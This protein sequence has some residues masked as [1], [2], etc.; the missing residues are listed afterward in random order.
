MASD[1]HD[2]A[3]ELFE[4]LASQRNDPSIRIELS[5]AY[6]DS[7]P[8]CGGLAAIVCKGSRAKKSLDELDILVD[9]HPESWLTFYARGTNHLH[10]PR[11]LRHSDAAASDFERCVELQSQSG[12]VEP[13]HLR[14]WISLG[15]A[16]AKAGRYEAA[17]DA[18]TRGQEV[19]P[20]SPE[21]EQHLAIQ[22]DGALLDFVQ[23]QRSLEQEI[24]TDLT[25]FEG[26]L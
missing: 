10:W 16:Y 24:D 14:T 3:I 9:E 25:F 8:S 5:L 2:R 19:F 15:Q 1:N 20:S 21:L 7:I 17:R 6:V 13:Y 11:A 4:Q 26:V 18:W 23:Q 22:D 12:S